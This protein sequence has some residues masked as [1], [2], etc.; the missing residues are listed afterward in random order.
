MQTLKF[1]IFINATR[2]KVWKTMLEDATYRQWTKVFNETSHFRGDWSEGSRMLFIGTDSEGKN[3]GGM[4]SQ[5]AKNIPFEY[6]SIKHI[7]ILEN[8]VEKPFEG[9][10]ECFENYSLTEKDGG[11]QLDVELTNLPP[12]FCEMMKDPWPKAL[13]ALKTLAQK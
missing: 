10:G 3:E 2:E 5:I 7:A 11:T 9:A 12:E 8:G 6:V 4:V 13:D 1:S